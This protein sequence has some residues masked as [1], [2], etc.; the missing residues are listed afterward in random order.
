MTGMWIP[1]SVRY[2]GS[3]FIIHQLGDKYLPNPLTKPE[4]RG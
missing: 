3:A 1:P 2:R 4:S